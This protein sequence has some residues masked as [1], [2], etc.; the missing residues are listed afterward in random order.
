VNELIDRYIHQVARKLPQSSRDDVVLELRT[1]IDDMVEARDGNDDPDAVRQ[2]LAELGNP[3]D[4]AARYRGEPRH[5]IGP[6]YYEPYLSVLKVVLAVALPVILGVQVLADILEE[7][8]GP[9]M[10]GSAIWG[11]A[12]T[13]M[14]VAFWVTLVFAVIERAGMSIDEAAG[15]SEP[16]NPDDLPELPPERSITLGDF[17]ASVVVVALIPIALV[18]QHVQSAFSDAGG[19]IPLLDP[20]LWRSWFPVLLAIVA[21]NLGIEIWKFRA[22][23]WSLPL[24]LSNL[25]LNVAFAG[26]FIA[27]FAVE[28]VWNP[29]YVTALAAETDFVLEGSAV[30]PIT[31]AVVVFISVWDV[32]DSVVKCRRQDDRS[33]AGSDAASTA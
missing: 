2:A 22:G 16:W 29:D 5:L 21:V 32:V 9:G 25:A 8:S 1:T 19:P 33:D 30:E 7:R 10:V 26:Y 11:T 27:L 20:D 3:R 23:R 17:V 28:D 14:L 18:W 15:R 12:M 24:V 4:L 13:G 6:D 31:I